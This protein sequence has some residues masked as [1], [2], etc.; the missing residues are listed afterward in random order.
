[1]P[2]L[3]IAEI[4]GHTDPKFTVRTYTWQEVRSGAAPKMEALL[5]ASS[6]LNN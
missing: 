2:P 1:M 6:A 4:L 5:V 3:Q